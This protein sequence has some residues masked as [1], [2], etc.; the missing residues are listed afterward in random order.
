MEAGRTVGPMNAI[1]IAYDGSDA[2]RGA[3][4]AAQAIYPR[5]QAAIVVNVWTPPMPPEVAYAGFA[6][7]RPDTATYQEAMAAAER[8][9]RRIAAEGAELALAAGFD[10]AP[11][12]IRKSREV[13]KTLASLA[14]QLGAVAIVA[15]CRGQSPLKGLVLGSVTSGLLREADRPVIVVPARAARLSRAA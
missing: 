6:P 5:R 12:A 2:A 7:I 14:E 4:E 11:R 13:A 8:E 9:A 10:A 3:I 15:G 1:V